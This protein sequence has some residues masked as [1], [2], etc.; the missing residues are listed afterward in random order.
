[1]IEAIYGDALVASE[2]AQTVFEV[3]MIAAAQGA[4][5]VAEQAPTRFKVFVVI[6]AAH[7]NGLAQRGMAFS[8]R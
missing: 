1:V 4:V 5:L 3:A 6:G 8:R 7:R 2:Q